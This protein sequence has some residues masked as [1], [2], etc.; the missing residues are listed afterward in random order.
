MN[1]LLESGLYIALP[2]YYYYYYYYYY[3]SKPQ[4]YVWTKSSILRF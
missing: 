3:I 1:V 4:N 2:Y